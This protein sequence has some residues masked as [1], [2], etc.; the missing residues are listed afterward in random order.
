MVVSTNQGQPIPWQL[1][2]TARQRETYLI[3]YLKQQ[4][5]WLCNQGAEEVGKQ[6]IT[7]Q[8]DEVYLKPFKTAPIGYKGVALLQFIDLLKDNYPAT[9]KECIEVKNATAEKW[10]STP[11]RWL[12]L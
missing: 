1:N 3:E 11:K 7:S 2:V 9:P 4:E 5:W 10:D 6:F 12:T 8:L